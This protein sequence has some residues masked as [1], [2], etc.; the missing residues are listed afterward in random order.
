MTAREYLTRYR[1]AVRESKEI[2]LEITRLRMQYRAPSAINYSDMPKAHN[3]ERD[4]SDYM[5]KLEE[6]TEKL[7]ARY[8]KCLGIM[9]DIEMR[10]DR[11]ENQEEREII[12]HRYTDI[13]DKGKLSSWQ[14]V[15]D[16]VCYSVRYVKSK[17]GS[18][19]QHFPMDNLCL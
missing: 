11:M 7:Y 4:M 19:L 10:L 2:E 3:S 8:E 13:T 1:N 12:R 17:H 9:I 5:V 6:L 14:S 16:S 18:A 15:A